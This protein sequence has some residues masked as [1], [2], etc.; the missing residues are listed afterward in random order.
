M[1]RRTFRIAG[2]SLAAVLGLLAPWVMSASPASASDAPLGLPCAHREGVQ[3]CG[4]DR[5][6][7]PLVD[8]RVRSWDGVP[9]EVRVVLP[10]E[11][12]GPLP[13]VAVLGGYPGGIGSATGEWLLPSQVN[14]AKSGYAVLAV[15]PRG[16]FHS[17]GY[18]QSFLLTPDACLDGYIR[19]ADARYEVRDVQHLAGLLADEGYADPKRIGAVGES[20]GGGQA[21]QLSAL[22]DRTRLQSGELVPWL[23]PNGLAM[24]IAGVTAATAWND[25]GYSLVPNG[26]L[27][28]T[29]AGQHDAGR[30]PA[31]VMKASLYAGFVALSILGFLPTEPIPT[32]HPQPGRDPD[33]DFYG[34][35]AALQKGEPYEDPIVKHMLA[36]LQANH[37]VAGI[38]F[39]G[40]PAPVLFANG[41]ADDLFPVEETVRY[42]ERVNDVPGAHAAGLLGNWGHGRSK[43]STDDAAVLRARTL[44]WLDRWIRGNESIQ[45]V[46]GIEAR[47]LD[48]T[49]GTAAP[50]RQARNWSAFAAVHRRFTEP[51]RRLVAS[52]VVDPAGERVDPV[53]AAK[54]ACEELPAEDPAGVV[55]YRFSTAEGTI[56]GSPA[57]T[58][59]IRV[60]GARSEDTQLA[61]RLWEVDPEAGQQRLI[62]RALYRPS[63]GPLTPERQTFELQ[64]T[65]WRRPAGRELKLELLGGDPPFGR[66]SNAPFELEITNLEL[67]LPLAG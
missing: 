12:P 30:Q 1:Q 37:S 13:L 53:T 54:M 20:Y 33:A 19:L 17:C 52:S 44:A 50:T 39:D 49:T 40:R 7:E 45:V 32:Y 36:E 4:W 21:L 48:C 41:F 24:R 43:P 8:R 38:P 63:G 47:P 5:T 15:A 28:S 59:D 27:M 51:A 23:S 60:L 67:D 6:T 46:E 22:R 57:I 9:L 14:L 66:P 3:I 2:R 31:G 26:R 55:S 58:A 25:L 11:R 62:S 18:R 10:P 56:L 34:W 42:L 61:A 64:G 35:G 29:G 65:G 16:T